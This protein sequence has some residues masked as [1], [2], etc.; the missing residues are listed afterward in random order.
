[1]NSLR[2]CFVG[3]ANSVTTRRWVEWFARRGHDTTVLTVEPAAVSDL[4]LVRQIKLAGS[5]G[6]GKLARLVSAGHLAVILRALKPD[7]VH[8]HYLRGLAWG[9]L[10]ARPHPCVVTPWGSD[11]LDEQGAFREWYSRRLTRAVLG[12]ADLVTVH[13]SYMEERVRALLPSLRRLA[14]IG[15]PTAALGFRIREGSPV[16]RYGR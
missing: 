5:S 12:M 3:P 14:R 15:W 2:L 9:L 10:V 1:M 16:G 6:A 7:V 8:A 13:S 4:K 11:V